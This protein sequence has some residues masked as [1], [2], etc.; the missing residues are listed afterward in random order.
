MGMNVGGVPL[1]QDPH[2]FW[3]MFVLIGA[4]TVAIAW[5]VVRWW[6]R[7]KGGP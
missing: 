3:W 5:L 4:I 1:G 7:S 6:R 2:G